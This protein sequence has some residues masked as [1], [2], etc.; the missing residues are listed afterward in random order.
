MVK[1]FVGARRCGLCVWFYLP[2]SRNYD[3]GVFSF[4]WTLVWRKLSEVTNHMGTVTAGD[5]PNGNVGDI[6]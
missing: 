6:P 5:E 2:N 1:R 3:L 4:G